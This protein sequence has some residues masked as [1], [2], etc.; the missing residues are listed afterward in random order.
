MFCRNNFI[1]VKVA[2]EFELWGKFLMKRTPRLLNKKIRTLTKLLSWVQCGCHSSCR[3]IEAPDFN[4]SLT[5]FLNINNPTSQSYSLKVRV[6]CIWSVNIMVLQNA[7]NIFGKVSWTSWY[8]VWFHSTLIHW[9]LK[10]MS[11]IF[12]ALFKCNLKYNLHNSNHYFNWYCFQSSVG[13]NSPLLQV[14]AC[15]GT[16]DRPLN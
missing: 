2:I 4:I 1:S 6:K 3:V 9:N 15:Q 16:V 5:Y 11:D 8:S 10:E 12:L 13:D 7:H 14:R